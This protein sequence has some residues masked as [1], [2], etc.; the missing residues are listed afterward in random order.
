MGLWAILAA[1]KS[2][3]KPLTSPS[4][5]QT[6]LSQDESVMLATVAVALSLWVGVRRRPLGCGAR[7]RAPRAAGPLAP[8]ARRSLPTPI[9]VSPNAN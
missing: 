3:T 4:L 7:A 9:P 5:R 8:K 6:N 1:P 2:L